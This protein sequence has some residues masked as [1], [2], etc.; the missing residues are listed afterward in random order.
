MDIKNM[1]NKMINMTNIFGLFSN[2][3][4]LEGL[5]KEEHSKTLVEFKKSPIYH[6]GMYKKLI[7]NH[8]NFNT[9]VLNFF[10]STNQEFD[11]NDVKEAG[12]YVVF[13]RAWSYISNVNIKNKG[14]I[15]A[16]K[17]YSDDNF[18]TSLDMGIAHF[19]KEELYERCALL[20]KV[21]KKSIKLLK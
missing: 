15:D 14:Y 3:E 1:Y 10:K 9:K 5:D 6:V 11:I 4:G 16:I 7:S 19:Q 17:H 12:E 8:V 20:L 2:D 21:K 13:N 18:H